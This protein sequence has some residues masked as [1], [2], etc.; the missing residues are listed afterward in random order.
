[1]DIDQRSRLGNLPMDTCSIIE[2]HRSCVNDK[3]ADG[4]EEI[5][6]VGVL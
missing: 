4:P 1:M 2:L 3:V 6:L 5:V